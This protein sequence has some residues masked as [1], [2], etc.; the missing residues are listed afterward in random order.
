MKCLSAA[1]RGAIDKGV[2]VRQAVGE[3]SVRVWDLE[4]KEILRTVDIP[5]AEGHY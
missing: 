3:W 5:N 2:T 4:H 1:M